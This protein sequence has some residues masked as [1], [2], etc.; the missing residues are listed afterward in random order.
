MEHIVG[1]M[2]CAQKFHILN[3]RKIPVK[4][5]GCHF[6]SNGTETLDVYICGWWSWAFSPIL[7]CPT[8]VP[9]K[10]RPRKT[11]GCL[12]KDKCLQR[13]SPRNLSSWPFIDSFFSFREV[14]NNRGHPFVLSK[15]FC[16][17]SSSPAMGERRCLSAAG[18]KAQRGWGLVHNTQPVAP[19]NRP[20]LWRACLSRAY[21]ALC[22]ARMCDSCCRLGS[23]FGNMR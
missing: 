21:L 1:A 5:Y 22:G 15:L 13:E 11:L 12:W 8:P 23:Y 20:C 16:I 19:G 9:V 10:F 2:L 4:Y 14:L 6:P 18:A 3:S 17:W 7:L